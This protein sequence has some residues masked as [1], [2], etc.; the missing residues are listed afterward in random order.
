VAIALKAHLRRVVVQLIKVQLIVC[1]AGG[2]YGMPV[3][4]A[5][6]PVFLHA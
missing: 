6:R 5:D 1:R 4:L 2:Q 3:T